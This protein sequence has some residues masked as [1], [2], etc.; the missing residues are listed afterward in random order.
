MYPPYWVSSK[1]GTYHFF[2]GFFLLT[3]MMVRFGHECP[4]AKEK[5]F[6]ILSIR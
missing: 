5:K 3:K 2:A 1:E 4:N 6:D